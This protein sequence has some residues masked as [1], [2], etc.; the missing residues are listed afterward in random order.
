MIPAGPLFHKPKSIIASR[1]ILYASL[2]LNII[3]FFLVQFA[4]GLPGNPNPKVIISNGSIIILLY[5]AIRNIGFG[6]KWARTMFLVLFI[7]NVLASPFYGAFIFKT[8]L[9]LGFLFILQMLLQLLGLAYLFSK[10]STDWFNSFDNR[11]Q[12]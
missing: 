11:S 5:I 10:N 1:N 3:G 2:F 6:K 4:L 9:A 12:N 8:N 7:M